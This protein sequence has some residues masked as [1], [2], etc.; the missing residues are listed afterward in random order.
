MD[1]TLNTTVEFTRRLISLRHQDNCLDEDI[2]KVRREITES[3]RLSDIAD[4]HASNLEAEANSLTRI[5]I[6]NHIPLKLNTL[7]VE[8]QLRVDKKKVE[9]DNLGK[10]LEFAKVMEVTADDSLCGQ[11]R[12]L[13]QL[14]Q[15]IKDLSDL[16][17]DI[18]N[19]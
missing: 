7:I 4:S 19:P 16:G 15:V 12:R 18:S 17:I 1:K 3:K 9:L 5:L 8:T 6:D 14:E 11:M 13:R 10:E 2:A